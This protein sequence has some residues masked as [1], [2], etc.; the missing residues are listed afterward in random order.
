NV[1]DYAI[2]MLDPNGVIRT[3][4]E[5]AQRIKG[6]RADEIIGKHF[7]IFYP[8]ETKYGHPEEELE[9]AK[10]EGRYE[11]EGWRLRKDGSAFWANVVITRVN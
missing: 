9:I 6:Y 2:F 5:G 1:K 8:E 10:A 7:S 11:E 4:N 3:W